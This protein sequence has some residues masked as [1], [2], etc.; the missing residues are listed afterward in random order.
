MVG[1]CVRDLAWKRASLNPGNAPAGL[2]REGTRLHWRND[3]GFAGAFEHPDV[4]R[5]R[6]RRL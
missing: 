5:A 3:G 2:S 6:G 1:H 4:P